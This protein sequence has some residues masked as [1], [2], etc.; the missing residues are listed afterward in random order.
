MAWFRLGIDDCRIDAEYIS[1]FGWRN[2][3]AGTLDETFFFCSY[4]S[5]IKMEIKIVGA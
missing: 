1:A 3:L 2:P 5:V 4:G